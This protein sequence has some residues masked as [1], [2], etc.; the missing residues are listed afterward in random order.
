M[1]ELSGQER[2]LMSIQI[3]PVETKKQTDAFL[4]VPYDLYGDDPHYVFPLL[5]EMRNFLDKGRN[6]FYRHAEARLWLAEKGG[7]VV[8][9]IGACVDQ[10]NNEHHDEKVGF[11]GFYEVIDDAEIAR[12]LLQT[13]AGWIA[14]QG[15][16]TMRG[17]GCFTSNH[18]WYG[19][20]VAGRFDRPVLGM[21]YNKRYYEGQFADFG[22]TGAKDLVAW[23]LET[24]GQ[25]PEK[26]VRVIER[27]LDK[28]G[29]TVRPMNM[30]RFE[31]DAAL[32]R[33]LYNACWSENWGFIPLDDEDFKHM[34]KD[35]KSMV[36]PELLLIAEME[37]KPVGFALSVPDF[38]QA[39]QPIRGKL[40]PFGWLKF[41]LGKRKIDAARTLLMGVLP[42]YRKMGLDMAMVYRTMTA[43][44]KDGITKGECSWVLAD[45]EPMN[46]I[47]EGYGADCYKTYRVFEKKLS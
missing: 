19:L 5:G 3:I 16:D 38:N 29:L 10:Y 23:W 41:L 20:Q 34:A 1:K 15:M 46:R 11:F 43:A 14:G 45:N 6:P 33:E 7:R 39:L 12:L 42:E 17:P 27:I 31:E 24:G 40:L 22:L 36:N 2:E 35:M 32:I 26:M 18:D 47:M 30:K 8:G 37:G 28:P 44:F 9:R 25:F 21:P 13:A 4:Q